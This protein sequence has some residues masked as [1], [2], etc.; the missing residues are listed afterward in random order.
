MCL[1]ANLG[2]GLGDI[3]LL[4]ASAFRL[5]TYQEKLPNGRRRI[6][7]IAELRGVENDRFVLQP[8]M[9]YDPASDRLDATGAMPGWAS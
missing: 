6:M 8:L 3:R 7:H 1:M 5:I 4:I 9:R 2:L